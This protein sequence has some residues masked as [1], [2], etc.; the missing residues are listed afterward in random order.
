MNH[1]NITPEQSPRYLSEKE[2]GKLTGFSLSKLQQD[3]FSRRGCPYL[4]IG[5][6]VRYKLEDVVE[7]MDKHRV[8]SERQ[9]AEG[10]KP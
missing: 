3:R 8:G 7:F 5:R 9:A 2:V 6:I 4:K 10:G 1:P